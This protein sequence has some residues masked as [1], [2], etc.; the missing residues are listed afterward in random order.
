MRWTHGRRVHEVRD[1]LQ[2]MAERHPLSPHWYLLGLATD[3]DCRGEGMASRLLEDMLS[4]C[5]REEQQVALETSK[6]SN[7][8]FYER[9]GFVVVDELLI[10]AR[11][12][13]WLML[14]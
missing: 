11:V 12:K 10:D 1:C 9:F 2:K 5:E 7:L 8:A 14:R 4:R 13:T 3:G 6:E